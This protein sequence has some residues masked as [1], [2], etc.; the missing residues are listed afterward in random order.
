MVTCQHL[1]RSL[2]FSFLFLIGLISFTSCGD[3]QADSVQLASMNTPPVNSTK[4]SDKRFLASAAEINMEQIMIGKLA[5]QRAT[6]E[7]VK[8]FA[9]MVEDAH[10][11]AKVSLGSIAIIKSISIPSGTTQAVQ[12]AYD[13]LNQ[14]L[15]ETFDQAYISAVVLGHQNAVSFL[16]NASRED[17]DPDVQKWANTLLTTFRDHLYQARSLEGQINPMSELIRE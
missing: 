7:E 9:R 5:T 1:K 12:D 11:D 13:R 6:S 14:E 17:H 15:P 2:L 8:S 10:R 4:E 3:K 16:E